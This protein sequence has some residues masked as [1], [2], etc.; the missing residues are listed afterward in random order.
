MVSRPLFLPHSHDASLFLPSLGRR[1]AG[2]RKAYAAFQAEEFKHVYL[3]GFYWFFEE[4]VADDES[5][6]PAVADVIHSFGPSL[7]FV[8][9]PYYRLVLCIFF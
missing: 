5:L 6:I 4:V 8:W 3:S 9:I 2:I 1:F 7:Q